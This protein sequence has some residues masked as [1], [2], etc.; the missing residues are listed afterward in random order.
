MDQLGR[1]LEI[2]CFNLA[3]ALIAQESGAHRVELCAGPAE[4][5]T[6]PALGAIRLTRELL[7]IELYPIIR[8]RGG[9]FLFSEEEFRIMQQDVVL[10][11]EAG[12]DGVVIGALRADGTVD[13]D[14]VARLV[15]LAYPLG[16]TF[17]RAFDWTAEPYR[18]LEE[19]I[20]IGCER[21]L[22]SG[23]RPLAAEGAELL[24]ELVNLADGRIIIMPGSGLRAANIAALAE[25][26]GASEFHSSARTL[27]ASAMTY[28]NSAMAEDQSIVIADK[29]EIQGMLGAL[30]ALGAASSP[31]P[32][33]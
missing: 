19:L 14:R 7:H 23:Q 24:H 6:T 1:K 27:R 12:C 11:R 5:G 22:T 18:A 4:G 10:C 28:A 20:G 33:L 3:S 16:V 26:T 17:H 31:T 25:R 21:I 30:G 15:E 8:P 9:D 13:K 32:A 2:C 29:E